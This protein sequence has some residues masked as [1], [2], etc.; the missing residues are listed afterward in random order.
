MTELGFDNEQVASASSTKNGRRKGKNK[1]VKNTR[2]ARIKRNPFVAFL[3]DLVVIVGAALILSLLV[4]T[5]LIRSF[6]VPSGSMLSTLQV[7]DRIIVNELVPNVV[8]IEHGDVLVFKDPGGWL[9][10]DVPSTPKSIWEQGTEW[11]LSAFGLAAPD[12][13]QHLVKRTIGLPGDHIKCCDASGHLVIN[14]VPITETY[15]DAGIKP[16]ETKFDVTVPAN[17]LWMMG[18]NRS[19]S[20]DSRFHT[21]LPSK[22]FVDKSFVV[23]RA[24][25]VSWPANHWQWLD[26]FSSVFKDVPKPQN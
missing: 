5:F 4:K 8:P 18:D 15:L 21:D 23:G 16:S 10:V 2:W 9:S 22:G 17:K 12:S 1:P 11:F 20:S 26:N 13:S 3:I 14:G 24:F 19:R 25:V 6:Y 7:D